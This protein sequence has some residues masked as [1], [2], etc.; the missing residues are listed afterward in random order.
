MKFLERKEIL[1]DP[2]IF[3]A[4]PDTTTALRIHSEYIRRHS[5]KPFPVFLE[6]DRSSSKFDDLWH[7]PLNDRTVFSREISM[8]AIINLERPDWRLTKVGIVPQ[9]KMKVWVGNLLLQEAE[10]FPLRGDLVVY[11]GYRHLIVNVVLEPTAYWHQTNVWLGLVLETTIPPEGDARPNP[12]VTATVP[13]ERRQT[14]ALP[15]A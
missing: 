3:K 14:K 12:F 6:V 15:E 5:P 11:N 2:E 8:P 13:S 9:Q 1:Y 7:Y 10:W 4:R